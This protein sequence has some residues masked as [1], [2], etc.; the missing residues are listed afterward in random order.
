M[1]NI[2]AITLNIKT[3]DILIKKIKIGSTQVQKNKTELCAAQNESYFK[4]QPGYSSH[5]LSRDSHFLAPALSCSLFPGSFPSLALWP[6]M[7]CVL[8]YYIFNK[9]PCSLKV[10]R[11]VFC[12]LQ[13]R[14]LINAFS[15]LCLLSPR[16]MDT[17]SLLHPEREH[18]VPVSNSHS[19]SRKWKRQS[20][21]PPYYEPLLVIFETAQVGSLDFKK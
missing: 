8:L 19:D 16:L 18:N 6:P 17:L 13:K 11:L 1:S 10:T 3:L 2:S 4:Q 15:E 14:T 20:V 9:S 5:R 21:D 12:R 7:D